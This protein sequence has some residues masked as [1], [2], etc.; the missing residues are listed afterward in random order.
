[1][2]GNLCTSCN[3]CCNRT[4]FGCLDITSEEAARLG[5]AARIRT[6]PDGGLNLMQPCAF[7]GACGG[8]GAYDVRP[9]A[10]RAYRCD[11]LKK[12]EGGTLT[13]SFAHDVVGRLKE[14]HRTCID[15]CRAVVPAE[16]WQ[17]DI[18]DPHAAIGLVMETCGADQ[19]D[20]LFVEALFL[21][22][23]CIQYTRRNFQHDYVMPKD[24]TA[25]SRDPAEAA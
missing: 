12:V 20:P 9:A 1:M 17:D 15:A 3:L 2:A 7:L 8:C 16:L 19:N 14:M 18:V 5:D 10:C 11:L 13:E 25:P 6:E 24:Q 4:F 21:W 22:N 23:V